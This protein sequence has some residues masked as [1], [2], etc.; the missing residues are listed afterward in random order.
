MKKSRMMIAKPA[1]IAVGPG[2]F[3]Y[4][5]QARKFNASGTRDR[6]ASTRNGGGGFGFGGPVGAYEHANDNNQIY[7]VAS[8]PSE[9]S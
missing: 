5:A 6:S 4:V 9:G 1:V 7:C 3:A 8:D 2:I